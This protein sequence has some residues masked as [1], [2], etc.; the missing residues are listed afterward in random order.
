MTF[1]GVVMHNATQ[2]HLQ[3]QSLL[4]PELPANQK[5]AC[6]MCILSEFTG[7]KESGDI[8]QNII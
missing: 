7:G 6:S 8:M 4:P 1:N 5:H 2:L 3:Q